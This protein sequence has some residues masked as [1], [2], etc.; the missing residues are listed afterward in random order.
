MSRPTP[1][2]GPREPVGPTCPTGPTSTADCAGSAGALPGSIAVRPP[3]TRLRE[4]LRFAVTHSLPA[5]AR[6]VPAPR[7]AVQTLLGAVGQPR[8]SAA[9]L[10]TLRDRYHGAPVLLGG[11]SGDTLVLLD[12]VDVAEFFARPVREL[13]LDAVDKTK[14]L[15]VLEP[16]GVVCSHGDLREERRALNDQVLA[17][18][19][20]THPSC[21]TYRTVIAE[22]CTRLTTGP[23]LGYARLERAVHRISRRIVL[24]EQAAGDEE[25]HHRLL[26]LRKEGN[27]GA[28]RRGPTPAARQRYEA[29]TGRLHVYARH[30]PATT[31]LGRAMDTACGADVD[32]VGQAHHWLLALDAVAAIVARTLLL[33]A[34][35]PAE[36]AALYDVP[37]APD[38]A[39]LRACVLEG[40]RLY[41]LVPDLLRILRADTTWRGV[42]YPAGTHVLV[43]IGFLQRDSGLV[44]GGSLFAPGRWLAE[45]AERDT[46]MAPFGHGEGRCPGDRLGLM[47]ATEVCAQLLSGHRVTGGRPRLD[48]HRPLPGVLNASG[49]QLTLARP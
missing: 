25:L 36:Q 13:A 40:L 30:A 38:T 43:P 35:H 18:H 26:A 10:R 33:L 48:P 3:R 8:W 7:P 34:A 6:G 2:P 39:R 5:F 19:E 14:M 28:V 37:H 45:G 9:T 1:P 20:E 21:G 31:L 44:P 11:A 24:G 47:A 46:L 27:W 23:T 22:E 12:P 32:P 4:S 29:A 41:P 16:T 15:T 49:S 42:P 17:H